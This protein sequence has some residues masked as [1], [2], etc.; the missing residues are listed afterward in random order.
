MM[1]PSYTIHPFPLRVCKHFTIPHTVYDVC[2][3]LYSIKGKQNTEE[4]LLPITDV[5]VIEL[6]V[7]WA[8][9]S[10]TPTTYCKQTQEILEV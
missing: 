6:M 2:V 9:I 8:N 5:T 10:S 3:H 1:Y 7:Y 4:A